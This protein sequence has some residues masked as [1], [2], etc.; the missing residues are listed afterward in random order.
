M[1]RQGTVKKVKTQK[2]VK[3]EKDLVG[4]ITITIIII[5]HW[6]RVIKFTIKLFF[7]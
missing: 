3:F 7:Q 4:L 6:S 5:L 2:K 1:K